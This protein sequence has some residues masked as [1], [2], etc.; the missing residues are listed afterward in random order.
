[1]VS[2]LHDIVNEAFSQ[3]IIRAAEKDKAMKETI[4]CVLITMVDAVCD[5]EEERKAKVAAKTA[6]QLELEMYRRQQ[7]MRQ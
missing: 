3:S 1:M 4:S 7:L 5:V 2:V 6:K